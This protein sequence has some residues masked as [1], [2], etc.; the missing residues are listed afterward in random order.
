MYNQPRRGGTLS[1]QVAQC[2]S[3]KTRRGEECGFGGISIFA[4]MEEK[5]KHPHDNRALSLTHRRSLFGNYHGRGIYLITVCTEDRQ[6][7]LGML[8]GQTPE[9]AFVE[10]TL[11]G[12]EV[13]RCWDNIPT[14]QK[15]LAEKKSKKT[16]KVCHREIKLLARQLMP[17]HLHGI[18]FVEREMDIVLGDVIRGFMVGCTRA[19]NT[20]LASKAPPVKPSAYSPSQKSPSAPAQPPAS[21]PSPSSPMRPLFEK[22]YHDRRLT[23]EG[24]LQNMIDYVLDNPRRLMLRCQN[25]GCFAVQRDVHFQGHKFSAVGNLKWLDYPM[26]AV[27]VR[28]KFTDDERKDYMNACILSARKGTV[29]IGAFISEYEKQVRDEALREDLPVIQLC[30]EQFSNLYKPSGDLFDACTT[31]HLLLLH[32]EGASATTPTARP[33]ATSLRNPYWEGLRKITREQCKALN[34]LAE[35][36]AFGNANLN[37]DNVI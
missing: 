13:L 33:A 36:L 31:G 18:I 14:I 37:S 34:A 23:R 9:E 2:L 21:S 4:A 25:A 32:E 16:G 29:L 22:G 3:K 7:L 1:R 15:Q 20:R 26:Q 30:H 12:E 24:Q 5:E 8:R 17:D 11:L 6:P 35:E 19:Y 10:P 28:R 27:H